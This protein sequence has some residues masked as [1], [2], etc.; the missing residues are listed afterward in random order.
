MGDLRK[1]EYFLLRYVPNAVRGRIR[2]HRL[3]ADGA[4]ENGPDGAE[5]IRRGA[6]HSEIGGGHFDACIL[7]HG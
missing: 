4:V 7:R 3:G 5:L 1:L 6:F 2:Q